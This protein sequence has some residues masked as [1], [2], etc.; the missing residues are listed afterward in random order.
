MSPTP[1][2]NGAPHR[3]HS[4]TEYVEENFKKDGKRDVNAY[5]RDCPG[6][7]DPKAKK[8]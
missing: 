6:V 7:E 4:W 1:C 8:K 5:R 2:S 3:A